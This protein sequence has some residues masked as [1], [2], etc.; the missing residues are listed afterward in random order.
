MTFLA[1]RE[2]H[3]LQCKR[4]WYYPVTV[5]Y[6]PL[7]EPLFCDGSGGGDAP[8][9]PF[10][11]NELDHEGS[12][13]CR[14]KI[15]PFEI[16]IGEKSDSSLS[17]GNILKLIHCDKQSTLHV[18]FHTVASLNCHRLISIGASTCIAWRMPHACIHIDLVFL[19][20]LPDANEQLWCLLA[21]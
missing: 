17:V 18:Y 8:V 7:E 5:H 4:F 6:P 10:H 14:L 12:F 20:S 11:F 3:H 19:H 16:M 13:S 2:F 15:V 1:S 9:P 21:S